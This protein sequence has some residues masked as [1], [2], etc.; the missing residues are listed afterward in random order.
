MWR[1]FAV[2]GRGSDINNYTD[3]RCWLKAAQTYVEE[4]VDEGIIAGVAHCQTVAAQP[5]DVDV[6][7]PGNTNN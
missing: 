1:S 5:D 7:V 6:S 3:T 2:I 4:T